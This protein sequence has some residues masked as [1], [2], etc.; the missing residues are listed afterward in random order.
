MSFSQVI[1]AVLSVPLLLASA[2]SA[3]QPAST[4]HP[5]APDWVQRSNQDA[6][7]LL[8]VMARF[9]PEAA[10]RL[11]VSG[12]DEQIVDLQPDF[13][14]R[15]RQALRQAQGDL[16]RMLA[17]EKDPAVRQDLEIM[18]KT[19]RRNI[20]ESELEEKYELLYVN[21]PELVFL[22]T[23][24]L[25]DDQVAPQR[26][27][28]AMV[29]LRKYAGMEPGTPSIVQLTEERTRERL[30]APGLMGPFKGEMEKNF[31]NEAAYIDGIGKL[32]QKYKI[33]GYEEP[34]ARLK[35]Q[36]AEY[37]AFLEKEL[38]PRARADF[39]L[40]P[41][42]YAF[43]LERV[44]VEMPP[45]QLVAVAHASFNEIQNEM[46]ALAPRVAREKGLKAADYRD[47][48]RELKKD[49][50]PGQSILPNYE[51]RI[52][53]IEQIIRREHLVTLPQRAMEIKLSSEA[54]SAA[55][56]APNMR[57]PRLVGNTGE[58]G[59]FML[60]LR[61]PAPPGSKPGTT[62][63]YDDFTFDAA[64]WTLTAHE[65]RPGH[66]LQFDSMVE[67]GVSTARAL[68]SFN[69][70]NVEGWGLYSEAILKPF[71]PADGQLISLQHRLLRAA[72]AFLDPELQAG[73]LKPEEA[74]RILMEDV[75]L[76]EAM[77]NQEVERYTFWAPAQAPSYFYGYTQ[78]MRLRADTEKSMGPQFDQERFHDFV[79][80]QG[81]IPPPLLRQAVF[82]QFVGGHHSTQGN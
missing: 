56:P 78:L 41:E 24:A 34:Y 10:A 76:S 54:E 21:L 47:V 9:N 67:K 71:M 46:M 32:F 5:A 8:K 45:D 35:Q 74:K 4:A 61:I 52:A 27:Q 69:S 65:G 1:A 57:P 33:A 18:I 26:R 40:A 15:E 73:K 37:H 6:Q 64:A 51:K 2:V 29:R 23:H 43:R 16:E 53:E 25:L 12:V 31:G 62:L 44:G 3:Q 82:A 11:G 63:Q 79:L 50:W 58:H 28:A 38:L 17:E 19:A 72:R 22:G 70:V 48:I 81:I 13:L 68:F 42:M 49:Q 77:A 7:V 59:V 30:K 36:M 75:C 60:P 20:R 80:A 55:T 14:E 39:R 66:E